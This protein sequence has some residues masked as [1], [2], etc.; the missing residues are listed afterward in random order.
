MKQFGNKRFELGL[1]VFQT[2]FVSHLLICAF[3]GNTN[4]CCLKHYEIVYNKEITVLHVYSS[5]RMKELFM[6]NNVFPFEY[7]DGPNH[8]IVASKVYLAHK[9]TEKECLGCILDDDSN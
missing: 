5:N 2:F 9:L 8:Y 1:Q 4:Y 6:M 7:I 3:F